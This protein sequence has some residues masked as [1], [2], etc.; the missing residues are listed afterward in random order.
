MT[1]WLLSL[2]SRSAC[3]TPITKASMAA[4]C[5]NAQL[6]P[7]FLPLPPGSPELT[8]APGPEGTFLL[9][10][11]P[12]STPLSPSPSIRPVVLTPGGGPSGNTWRHFWLSHRGRGILLAPS[13]MLPHPIGHRAAAHRHTCSKASNTNTETPVRQSLRERARGW[14]GRL[15]LPDGHRAPS[16]PSPDPWLT[17]APLSTQPRASS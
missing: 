3:P 13:G 16:A 15:L 1:P 17:P 7:K 5:L 9:V 6:S 12:L 11:P 2:S 8:T 14:G 10:G 4:G